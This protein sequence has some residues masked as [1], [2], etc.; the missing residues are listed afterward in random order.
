MSA[1]FISGPFELDLLPNIHLRLLGLIYSTFEPSSRF[2]QTASMYLRSFVSFELNSLK[3]SIRFTDFSL[4]GK[5][6]SIAPI[7]ICAFQA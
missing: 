6:A 3:D 2:T 4:M 5:T 1:E 7:F